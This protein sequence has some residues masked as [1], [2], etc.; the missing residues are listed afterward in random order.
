MSKAG[1]RIGTYTVSD[2]TPRSGLS[3]EEQQFLR[4]ISDTTMRYLQSRTAIENIHRGERMVR[5]LGSF[6]EGGATISSTEDMDIE[7]SPDQR[8]GQLNATQQNAQ[9]EDNKREAK[10]GIH[11]PQTMVC[12]SPLFPN[13]P[14]L[15]RLQTA[16]SSTTIGTRLTVTSSSPTS[17]ANPFSAK[18]PSITAPDP[19][20]K[21]LRLAF[22][23]ASNVLREAMEVEGALFLDASISSFAGMIENRR[24]SGES[25]HKDQSGRGSEEKMQYCDVL[26]FSTTASSSIDGSTIPPD[27]LKV[28][29]RLMSLLLGR[30]PDGKVFNFDL[31]GAYLSGESGLGEGS[32]IGVS[33]SKSGPEG[34]DKTKRRASRVFQ[35]LEGQARAITHIFPDA[36]S[37]AIVPLW[38]PVK[39]RWFACG[40]LWTN[41]PNR[42]FTIE[43]E[44]SFLRAFGTTIMAEVQRI[45]TLMSEKA[46]NDFLG[47]LSHELRSPLHGVIAAVELLNDSDIDAFQGDAVHTIE[48]EY[49]FWP[50]KKERPLDLENNNQ[51]ICHY[52]S[53]RIALT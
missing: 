22:S 53:H 25:S 49:P 6:V 13:R 41:S 32:E 31:D 46:K 16:S 38:D 50:A 39:E 29:E 8:E 26:G 21:D 42:V 2:G 5:G 30:Y 18:P 17:C 47:S 1:L 12:R 28:P 45:N 4:D 15:P 34:T 10:F 20:V 24:H 36:R 7:V 51:G 23:R 33:D 3:D 43:G 40:I 35:S 11:S 19:H 37:V 27:H 48:S 44:L 52:K 14:K 9:R